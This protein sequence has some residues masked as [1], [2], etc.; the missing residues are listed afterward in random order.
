MSVGAQLPPWQ[1]LGFSGSLG[2]GTGMKGR[3]DGSRSPGKDVPSGAGAGAVAA[4]RPS[5]PA[6]PGDGLKQAG[7]GRGPSLPKRGSL[8]PPVTATTGLE[9]KA[10]MNFPPQWSVADG[11]RGLGK[12][13]GAGGSTGVQ[14]GLLGSEPRAFRP[15]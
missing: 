10:I 7:A 9:L 8:H 3:G 1:E 2:V 11:R 4:L 13:L 5:P 12:G 6:G 14:L 15:L